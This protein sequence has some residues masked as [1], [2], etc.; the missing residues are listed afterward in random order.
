M[1]I[2]S[3]P[4]ADLRLEGLDAH[5]AEIRR[6]ELLLVD[7]GSEA[8]GRVDGQPASSKPLRTSDRIEL[9]DWTLSFF[10]QEFADHGIPDGRAATRIRFSKSRVHKER[11][12]KE[13]VTKL[14]TIPASI[15]SRA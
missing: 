8:P 4:D 12:L 2:G 11:P 6:D 15:S 5:Q 3:A 7:L 9:G 1:V 13:A 14:P 10:W